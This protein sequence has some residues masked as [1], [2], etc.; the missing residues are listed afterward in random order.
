[1]PRT[2]EQNPSTQNPES[3]PQSLEHGFGVHPPIVNVVWQTKLAGQPVWLHGSFTQPCRSAAAAPTSH[4][5]S[6]GHVYPAL[7]STGAQPWPSAPFV[8]GEQIVPAAHGSTPGAL[9]ER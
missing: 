7:Q 1:V 3:Q 5:D 9:H 8:P 4:S 2:L 6:V